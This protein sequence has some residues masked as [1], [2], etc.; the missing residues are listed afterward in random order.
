MDKA[1]T[2]ANLSRRDFLK[3]AGAA[4][5]FLTTLEAN[6][7]AALTGAPARVSLAPLSFEVGPGDDV[8]LRMQ[9]ELQRAL[10]K[11]V[12]QRRWVMVIDLRKCV[13][14]HACTIAC[15][16]ENK[17]PPGVVYRPVLD[18]E[19]GAY[20]N[21]TR[22][23]LPKPCMQCENPPCVPVCP[24]SAT[25]KDENGVVVIDYDQ[26]IGCRYCIT[27]CPYASRTFDF[28]STYTE[29]TPIAEGLVVGQTT[30]DDYERAANFEY[31]EATAR[32][33]KDESPIG[34]VRKCHFC[35]HRLA[36]GMLPACTTTC[37]GRAT[38]FG[39]AN[40]PD[41]VV[42]DLIASPNVMRLKEELGTEPRVY[43]LV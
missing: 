7:A 41:G 15:I 33:G 10:A 14:C 20:P 29:G 2:Q 11:P 28:G 9:A 16:A 12:D 26:C 21:V 37:I 43:Y 22:K 17:L 18:E 40:D 32:T 42:A 38:F 8:I 24:V 30:A 25:Y 5:A 36:E 39:D 27:A 4:V 31:Q 13:A 19:I 35:L 1:P 23:F 3:S 34:N 6:P